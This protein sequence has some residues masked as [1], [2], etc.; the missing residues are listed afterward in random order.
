MIRVLLFIFT[1]PL[2]LVL[3][4]AVKPANIGLLWSLLSR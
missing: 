4:G 2:M 3:G 1:E